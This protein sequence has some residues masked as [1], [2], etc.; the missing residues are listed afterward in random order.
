MAGT[1]NVTLSI[2]DTSGCQNII[3]HPVT[4]HNAP[5]SSF[6]FLSA[7]A[8][9]ATQFTDLSLAPAGDT[10]VSWYW[11]FN[12]ASPGTDTSALQ[13][14]THTYILPGTYTVSLT[15]KT[16]HGCSD[17]KTMPLQVWN[18]PTA[19]FKYTASPC[20]NGL[21]Q[22][23][24]SSWSYQATVTSWN[25]EFE[26]YQ[27]GTG[28]NPTHSYYAVDSCYDVKL[29]ITDLR[30]CVDTLIKPVCV[31]PQLTA[32][33]T[34]QQ[35]CFSQPMTFSPAAHTTAC[36]GLPDHLQLEFWR[37]RFGESEQQH[38]ET[39]FAYLFRSRILYHQLHHHRHVRL[40]GNGLPV[41]AGACSACGCVLL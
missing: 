21:V 10:L 19:H 32:T 3:S 6:T 36:S 11:D 40:P 2:A 9:A 33:F 31:P 25:W 28:Q 16:E 26:P 18:K 34:Y 7:C 22:F 27:Y 38:P 37:S 20:A 23:Q 24:D 13:N 5:A 12:L 4:I 1:F 29:M 39:S 15:T 8:E 17:T 14:P 35:A 41:R 30:G